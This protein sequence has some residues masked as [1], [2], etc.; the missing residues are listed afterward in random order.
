MSRKI[1]KSGIL[2][3]KPI[4]TNCIQYLFLSVV[5]ICIV[6]CK[7]INVKK[8]LVID[9]SYEE[10]LYFVICTFEYKRKNP[11]TYTSFMTKK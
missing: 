4:Y 3:I 1:S 8:K 10:I 11:F 2:F 9:F 7:N 6:S 5:F